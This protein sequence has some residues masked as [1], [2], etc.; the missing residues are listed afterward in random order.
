MENNMSK[1]SVINPAWFTDR[2]YVAIVLREYLRPV[3]GYDNPI[4]PPTF[5]MRPTLQQRHP[6]NIDPLRNGDN[7]CLIDSIASQANRLEPVLDEFDPRIVRKVTVKVTSGK[8]KDAQ[9]R[10]LLE[11][12]HRVA[13]AVVRFS[14]KADCIAQALKSHDAGNS[15]DLAKDFATS[16]VFGAWNSRDAGEKI[17]RVFQSTI[18]ATN[19]EPLTRASQ[20]VPP[21]NYKELLDDEDKPV[22]DPKTPDKK[23]SNLGLLAV[24]VVTM[25]TKEKNKDLAFRVHGGI[26]VK[27]DIRRDASINLVNLRAL[28]TGYS[29]E[30]TVDTLR[31]Y[32]L[33]LSLVALLCDQEFTL[34]QECQ[35][36]LDPDRT[37]ER[38]KQAEERGLAYGKHRLA[39]VTRDGKETSLNITYEAAKTFAE[40]AARKMQIDQSELVITFDPSKMRTAIKTTTTEDTEEEH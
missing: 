18:R 23:L 28:R 27:G 19:V 39:M 21:F 22:I 12:G 32:I 16:L 1:S 10:S 3:G 31:A 35:L 8:K 17:P 7:I 26:I 30:A 25:K 38:A 9:Y 11:I 6:Y 4:F 33:G 36:V 34:R 14:D 40:N 37:A 2:Q 20:Y 29:K 15:V 13:D 5:A 24:P